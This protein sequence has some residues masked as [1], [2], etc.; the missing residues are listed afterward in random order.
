MHQVSQRIIN[1]LEKNKFWFKTF[2]HKPVRTS[3]EAAL[4]R[5][6]YT[7]HQGAKALIL[8]VY[9]K[10]QTAHF[11]MV[12]LP[13]DLKL[14]KNLFK[15]KLELKSFRFATNNEVI[16]LTCG[17]LPGGIPP[18]GIL[19]N[20]PTYVDKKLLD[21]QKIIFNAGDRSLSV[22]MYLDDYLSLAKAKELLISQAV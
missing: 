13:G 2:H 17:V 21:N 15:Q 16:D 11:V 8:K 5:P 22:A 9:P 3:Q 7:I 18:L 20:L 12:V 6:D 10:K 19:F 1:L 4:V 14:D